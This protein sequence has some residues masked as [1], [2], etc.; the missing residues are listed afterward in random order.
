VFSLNE[1][2]EVPFRKLRSDVLL[3]KETT[4]LEPEPS[5]TRSTQRVW[6]LCWPSRYLVEAPVRSWSAIATGSGSSCRYAVT[7]VG[8]G[9]HNVDAFT[10]DLGHEVLT[11]LLPSRPSRRRQPGP[12]PAPARTGSGAR[13]LPLAAREV[14]LDG[15][16]GE[17]RASG[18]RVP[19]RDP[20]AKAS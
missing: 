11:A 16:S 8:H 6:A 20:G 15:G 7:V 5:S 14:E 1:R 4:P 13:A 3:V 17:Q 18:A 12:E 19:R 9:S 10:L 2:V